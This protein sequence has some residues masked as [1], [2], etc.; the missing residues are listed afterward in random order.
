[1]RIAFR[2][3]SFDDPLLGTQY[4]PIC[5]IEIQKKDGKWK[6]QVL[7]IDSGADTI[8]MQECDCKL[9]GYSFEECIPYSYEDINRNKVESRIRR[10]DIKIGDFMINAVP[11]SFATN[12]IADPVLGRSKI[13]EILDV[14]FDSANKYTLFATRP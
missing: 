1:M 7:K 9:L 13:F 3:H 10:F 2:W 6:R 5:T 8:L 12:P 11:V 14:F 4:L